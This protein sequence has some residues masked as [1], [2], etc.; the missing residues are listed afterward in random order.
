[1]PVKTHKR[2]HHRSVSSKVIAILKDPANVG[3]NF[4][5]GPIQ[6]SPQRLNAIAQAIQ[7]GCITIAVTSAVTGGYDATYAAAKNTFTLSSAHITSITDKA[8]IIHEAVHAICDQDRL[9]F[10]Q[11]L[12]EVAAYTA[13]ALYYRLHESDYTKR[14]GV[15]EAKMDEVFKTAFAL[16]DAILL[17]QKDYRKEIEAVAKAVR[18]APKYNGIRGTKFVGDGV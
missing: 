10:R 13:Q 7:D 16:A 15:S 9:T 5:V 12:G 4:Q 18:H 8:L 17:G 2:H 1:M 6:V 14:I 3:I 11:A